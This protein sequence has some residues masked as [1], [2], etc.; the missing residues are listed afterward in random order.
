MSD[1]RQSWLHSL[2]LCVKCKTRDAYTMAGHWLCAECSAAKNART[3]QRRR[4]TDRNGKE[5]ATRAARRQFGLCTSCGAALAPGGGTLC[6][7]CAGKRK[8]Y[9]LRYE[10]KHRP[11]Y[12]WPRGDNG[13]CYQCNKEPVLPG[14]RT[15][16]RCY[17]RT[18]AQA[19]QLNG[20]GKTWRREVDGFW[21]S[22]SE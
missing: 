8:T 9:R 7:R 11:A 2:G 10:A 14:K 19:R 12:N 1:P 20:G 18:A 5:R 6:K 21:K 15:C 17:E 3:R 22:L 13:I 4:E 16:R